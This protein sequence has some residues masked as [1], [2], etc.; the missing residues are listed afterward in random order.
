M[1]SER[2]QVGD[3]LVSAIGLDAL[4]LVRARIA[5]LIRGDD[6]V[7]LLQIRD[8][9]PPRA[10]RFGKAVQENDWRGRRVARDLHVE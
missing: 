9:V 4:W 8:D 5:T 3:D 2:D 7:I 6:E 10:M 1:I